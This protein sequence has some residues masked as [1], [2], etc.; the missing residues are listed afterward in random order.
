MI[1]HSSAGRLSRM[2][3]RAVIAFVGTLLCSTFSAQSVLAQQAATVVFADGAISAQSA[4]KGPRLVGKGSPLVEGDTLTVGERS[5]AVVEF[6]DQ[7]RTTLRPNTVI[8]IEQ[9]RHQAAEPD[10]FV[11][12]LVKGGIRAVTGLIGKARPEAVRIQTPNATIG[13]RG[14]SFDARLCAGDCAN[15]RHKTPGQPIAPSQ[16]VVGRVLTLEGEPLRVS[17]ASG[18][19]LLRVGGAIHEA[20][21]LETA[22]ATTAV[23]VFDDRTR[24]T[25][26]P[27]T[28]FEV[29]TWRYAKP[30]REA[31][32]IAL[33]LLVGAV[34]IATGLVGKTNPEGFKVRV[35]NSTVG[36]RG[37]G[38]DLH[39]TG[40][41]ANAGESSAASAPAASGKS[42]GGKAADSATPPPGS[43]L[44]AATWDGAISVS[45]AACTVR[46]GKGQSL[47][48]DQKTGASLYL[49]RTPGFLD[50]GSP[51]PD[52]VP[53]DYDQ[54]F[55]AF[56][57][58][59]ESDGLYAYVR[60]GHLLVS[61]DG[62]GVDLDA[63]EAAY[64][65]GPGRPPIRLASIP[66][67]IQD[68][69]YPVPETF[70][71]NNGSVLELIRENAR[72]YDSGAPGQ[73]TI[74]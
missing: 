18:E 53:F 15:E 60:D 63:G 71:E 11:L 20:E 62:L 74:R 5:F 10:G 24:I 21:V 37:T 55:G 48:V 30:N 33:R 66:G 9:F 23:I 41:C 47:Y 58:L 35:V 8:G 19:R 44:F 73:C 32:N 22:A 54:L 51:R 72:F 65:G 52:K 45:T 3:H 46:L 29:T 39:C 57:Q 42:C 50:D 56:G 16:P 17:S 36:I 4:G 1:G 70:G 31:G 25:L 43:G 49:P 64:A 26:K 7:T 12:R 2:S 61:Q 69:P 38:F 14:T 68:D 40:E 67:F 59:Q 28:R 6:A 27:S 34:R 13:I